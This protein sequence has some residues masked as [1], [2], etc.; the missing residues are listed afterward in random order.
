M[1]YP[2][3][4]LDR[5]APAH[6][7]NL[8]GSGSRV[9]RAWTSFPW[10]DPFPPPPPPRGCP[11]CSA[12]SP[13]LRIGPTSHRRSSSVCVLRLSDTVCFHR[14]PWDLPVSFQNVSMHARGLRPRRVRLHHQRSLQ[15]ILPS[16][17]KN[18]VGTL[19]L[20]DDFAARYPAC[21][22]LYQRPAGLLTNACV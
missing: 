15:S 18:A 14:R 16:V 12:A 19:I 5:L 6:W 10:P 3:V 8:A 9:C 1:S 11:L 7:A 20:C 21:M 4:L 2:V 13:V 22:Y 17:L